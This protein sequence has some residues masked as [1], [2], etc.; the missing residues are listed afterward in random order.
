M[1]VD[2]ANEMLYQSCLKELLGSSD[3]TVNHVRC[4]ILY[5]FFCYFDVKCGDW[6]AN[7]FGLRMLGTCRVVKLFLE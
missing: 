6:T 3:T 1:V 5:D 4:I 2:S 7:L